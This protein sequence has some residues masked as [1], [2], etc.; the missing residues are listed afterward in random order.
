MHK[1]LVWI[2][3]ICQ[4][5]IQTALYLTMAR[6]LLKASVKPLYELLTKYNMNLYWLYKVF[7]I[8]MILC[9]LAISFLVLK[10]TKS[11]ATA[12]ITNMTASVILGVIMVIDVQIIT[13]RKN[14]VERN[15]Q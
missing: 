11:G 14:Y 6:P 9:N 13:R 7:N 10:F 15:A 12:G 3:L 1:D 5:I 8:A 4:L 2:F